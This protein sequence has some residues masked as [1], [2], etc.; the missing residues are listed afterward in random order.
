MT[1]EKLFFPCPAI[2][3]VDFPEQF[4]C[5]TSAC[6]QGRRVGYIDKN[7]TDDSLLVGKISILSDRLFLGRE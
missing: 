7:S 1:H 6:S 2:V 5:F 4:L 3:V